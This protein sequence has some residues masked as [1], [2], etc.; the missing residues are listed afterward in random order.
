MS[1]CLLSTASSTEFNKRTRALQS[2]L[3]Q[4]QDQH[5]I[6][7]RFVHVDKDMAEI[8]A[9]RAVW[10]TAK[11][12]V[13]WWHLRKAVRER[14]ARGRLSTTPYNPSSAHAEFPFI[15]L[16]FTPAGRPDYH[17]YEGGRDSFA[18]SLQVYSNTRGPNSLLVTLPPLTQI[19]TESTATKSEAAIPQVTPT[20]TVRIPPLSQRPYAGMDLIGDGYENLSTNE[21]EVEQAEAEA[22]PNLQRT[23][24]TR[25]FCPE[26]HRKPIEIMMERH[27][28]AHSLIPGY[29]APTPEGIRAWAV[30]S[31][32]Q[33][34]EENGLAEVWAYLW[35]NWY[36]PGR[37]NLWARAESPEI[38]IL[39]TTMMVES[40]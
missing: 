19:I 16:S 2:W 33:Y 1:Y 40:Q 28:C 35:G 32:Y 10:P 34:C 8:G 5:G 27:L 36:R 38:P 30:K 23:R 20:M 24:S 11:I 3:E 25:I 22:E 21:H 15:S 17:D 26:E 14:L 29:S 6:I 12:Q 7:P 39:K 4:L 37:W 31:M 18:D 9:I 13:C